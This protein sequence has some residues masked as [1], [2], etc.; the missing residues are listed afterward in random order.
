MSGN[1]ATCFSFVV[2]KAQAKKITG[3]RAATDTSAHPPPRSTRTSATHGR[4]RTFCQLPMW[5]E[6]SGVQNWMRFQYLSEAAEL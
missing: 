5:P 2:L 4:R 3:T 1:R 6:D